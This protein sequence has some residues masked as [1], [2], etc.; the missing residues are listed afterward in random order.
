MDRVDYGLERVAEIV[1]HHPSRLT[2]RRHTGRVAQHPGSLLNQILQVSRSGPE[3][4]LD[5][6]YPVDIDEGQHRSL[7]LVIRGPVRSYPDQKPAPVWTPDL[8]LLV[9]VL[10]NHLF[11]CPFE[12]RCL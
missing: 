2:N 5:L 12:I 10:G 11:Y 4:L 8:H 7:D 9:D 3:L 1:A 6:L